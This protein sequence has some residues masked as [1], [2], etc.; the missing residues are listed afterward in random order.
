MNRFLKISA[1][2]IVTASFWSFPFLSSGQNV[3][4]N[5]PFGF[6]WDEDR[7]DPLPSS[8]PGPEKKPK[9][10]LDLFNQF[11]D[12]SQ[13]ELENITESEIESDTSA[14]LESK[15]MV[16]VPQ[17]IP[18]KD[19]DAADFDDPFYRV[20][21]FQGNTEKVLQPGTT[22]DGVQFQNYG[23][24]EKF[25]ERF[26]RESGFPLIRYLAKLSTWKK[27][28]DATPAIKALKK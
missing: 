26:Y 8:P 25:I 5:N 15:S 11:K 17:S 2:L 19:Y 20:R 4:S 18:K 3:E 9:G 27:E 16:Q 14:V 6:V 21:G 23:D 28:A 24:S 22:L 7:K 1:L 10:L 12:D 13:P